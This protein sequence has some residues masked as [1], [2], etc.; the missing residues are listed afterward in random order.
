MS[1]L[2]GGGETNTG[3]L[4][5][6]IAETNL[7]TLFAEDI[8]NEVLQKALDIAT[9]VRDSRSKWT[10][11][12]RHGLIAEEVKTHFE[13]KG[14]ICESGEEIRPLESEM[15]KLISE[16]LSSPRKD[17]PSKD[18]VGDQPP[19]AEKLSHVNEA[20]TIPVEKKSRVADLIKNS[21]QVLSEYILDEEAK[22]VQDKIEEQQERF[23]QVIELDCVLPEQAPFKAQKMCD[24]ETVPLPDE[25]SDEE[26]ARIP[27][28]GKM[29]SV[30]LNSVECPVRTKMEPQP[31]ED[32]GGSTRA[33]AS[34]SETEKGR[35]S[36][37][38][39]K[40]NEKNKKMGI[41]ARIMQFLRRPKHKARATQTASGK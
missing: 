35:A 13:I 29:E 1:G 36:L 16:A 40:S 21:K 33:V 41:G 27:S 24:P 39:N 5:V 14:Q 7:T 37:T 38:S 9:H 23:L 32:D 12:G 26:I 25:T 4:K 34:S 10:T 15:K 22:L 20:N 3:N 31:N 18:G 28:T 2:N 8:V 19:D 30:D 11:N 17:L 6:E